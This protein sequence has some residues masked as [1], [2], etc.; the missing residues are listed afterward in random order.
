MNPP[1]ANPSQ[2][3]AFFEPI[4]D[5]AYLALGA[6]PQFLAD[7]AIGRGLAVRGDGRSD[8]GKNLVSSVAEFS[9][10]AALSVPYGHRY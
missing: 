5:R 2:Q 10:C 6:D 3:P 1:R 9:W 4:D 8:E 7:H